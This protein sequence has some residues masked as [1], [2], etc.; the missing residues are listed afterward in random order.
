VDRGQLSLFRKVSGDG[1]GFHK[2]VIHIDSQ[3]IASRRPF[4]TWTVASKNQNHQGSCHQDQEWSN[5][6]S[7]RPGMM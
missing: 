2:Q 7:I 6:E 4:S 3:N 1:N 5:D